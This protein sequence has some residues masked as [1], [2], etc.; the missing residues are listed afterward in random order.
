M[1][2]YLLSIIGTILISAIL[3]AIIPDGKTASVIKAMT[4]TACVVAI[5]FPVLTFL[6]A[7]KAMG[8]NTA[9]SNI[10]FS[11]SV[12]Q[13]DEEFIKYYSDMRIQQTELAL[14]KELK[15]KFGIA[16]DVTVLWE[17]SS[18]EQAIIDVTEKIRIT[19]IKI[20]AKEAISEEVEKTMCE[21]LTKN[22]CSEVLIE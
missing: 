14:R 3:T 7:E 1:N 18:K 6:K 20:Q 12:I 13:T 17:Y 10:F 8:M 5:V 16:L 15:E 9:I 2:G 21:Y 4:K 19:Q 11:E 22:Y